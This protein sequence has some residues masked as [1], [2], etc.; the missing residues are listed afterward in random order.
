VSIAVLGTIGFTLFG[1]EPEKRALEYLYLSYEIPA[2]IAIVLLISLLRKI[3]VQACQ[4]PPQQ[5]S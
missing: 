3:K 4:K 5:E 1:T 2:G